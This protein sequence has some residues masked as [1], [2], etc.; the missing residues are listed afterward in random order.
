[1]SKQKLFM[2]KLSGE[3]RTIF[4]LLSNLLYK[5]WTEDQSKSFDSFLENKLAVAKTNPDQFLFEFNILSSPYYENYQN[6]VTSLLSRNKTAKNYLSDF[7]IEFIRLLLNY[8][9]LFTTE[10]NPKKIREIISDKTI[11]IIKY[12]VYSNMSN[13]I[14][15]KIIVNVAGTPMSIDKNV[16]ANAKPVAPSLNSKSEE[17]NPNEILINPEGEDIKSELPKKNLMNN[18]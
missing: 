8:S 10:K 4:I 7:I 18:K 6:I 9:E 1:M 15:D 17:S 13:D 2:Y 16:L 14:D 3:L 5:K 12:V 11:K